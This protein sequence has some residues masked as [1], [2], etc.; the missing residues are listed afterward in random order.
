MVEDLIKHSIFNSKMSNQKSK[1]KI[2][3]F[4]IE[5]FLLNIEY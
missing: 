4:D 5:N 1:Y 3:N 2:P